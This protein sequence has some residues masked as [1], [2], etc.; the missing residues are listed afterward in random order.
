MFVSAEMAHIT[1]TVS[2]NDYILNISKSLSLKKIRFTDLCRPDGLE[3]F[4]ASDFDSLDRCGGWPP[5]GA[6]EP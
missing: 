5:G 1:F 3:L 2:N 4:L 6:A